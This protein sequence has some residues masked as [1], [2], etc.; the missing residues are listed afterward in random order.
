MLSSL[1]VLLARCNAAGWYLTLPSQNRFITKLRIS[2]IHWNL[3]FLNHSPRNLKPDHLHP[4][5][6][7]CFPKAV[8]RNT[9]I[10]KHNKIQHPTTSQHTFPPYISFRHTFQLDRF[11]FKTYTAPQAHATP[12]ISTL[13][14]RTVAFSNFAWASQSPSQ[15]LHTV[16]FAGGTFRYLGCPGSPS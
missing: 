14:R 2:I 10:H 13:A 1:S 6:L 11:G 9:S 3:P 5:P 4:Y 16:A 12:A 7:L 8:N 15:P